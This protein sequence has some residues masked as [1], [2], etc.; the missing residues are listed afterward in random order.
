MARVSEAP[1]PDPAAVRAWARSQG[2]VV[3]DRGRL[4][5]ALLDAYQQTGSPGTADR[6]ASAGT[7]LSAPQGPPEG[8]LVDEQPTESLAATVRR[9]VADSQSLA[10]ELRLLRERVDRLERAP[11]LVRRT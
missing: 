4:P 6:D 10:E 2:L 8:G 7:K 3:G 9:L 5:R 11:R 1:A